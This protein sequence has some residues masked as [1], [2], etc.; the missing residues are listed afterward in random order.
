MAAAEEK[1]SRVGLLTAM[2]GWIPFEKVIHLLLLAF[3][4]APPFLLLTRLRTQMILSRS[5]PSV[6]Q[7]FSF[8][9]ETVYASCLGTVNLQLST[10]GNIKFKVLEENTRIIDEQGE[11]S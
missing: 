1:A 9:L 6:S 10:R 11:F 3:L 4:M 8:V 5:S 7:L 2:A